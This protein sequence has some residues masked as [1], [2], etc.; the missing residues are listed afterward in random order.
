MLHAIVATIF[1]ALT[2]ES[3]AKEKGILG[4]LQFSYRK[5]NVEI[6]IVSLASN[7]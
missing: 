2:M 6:L 4:K 7:L 5:V 1:V 3:E